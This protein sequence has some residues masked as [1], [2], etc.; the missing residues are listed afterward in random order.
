MEGISGK[1]LAML[2]KLTIKPTKGMLCMMPQKLTPD[3]SPS[4]SSWMTLFNCHKLVLVKAERSG[5][6]GESPE[7]HLQGAIVKF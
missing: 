6:P 4:F 5:L 2:I 3:S 7:L 1:W